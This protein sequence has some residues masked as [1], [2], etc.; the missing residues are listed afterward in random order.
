MIQLPGIYAEIKSE[1]I[2]IRRISVLLLLLVCLLI[3]A[4]EAEAASLSSKAGAVTTSAGALNVRKQ[5]SSG[6]SV[7]YSLKKGSYITL[8]EKHGSWW[9]VEYAAGKYGYCHADYITIVQGSPVTVNTRSGS[10]N[11]R[12]GAGTSY[13]KVGSLYKGQTVLFLKNS[14]GWS[15]VL[16]D[17]VKTGWVSEQYLSNYNAAVSLTVP[18]YKQSDVRWAHLMIGASGKTFDQIGCATTAIAMMESYRQGRNIFPDEMEKQLKYTSSGNVY[19]PEHY[20]TVTIL[21]L[22]A[23]YEK[24]RQG[25]PVLLGATN[26][27]GSQHWVVVVGF[28]GG[29]NLR[30]S[31]FKIHDPGTKSRYNLQQFLDVYPNFY[32]YFYY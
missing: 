26:Q 9:K 24:L 29:D 14:G 1:V 22:N 16:Y 15:R 17:G 10:L 25:R 11:V 6:S 18:N 5:P 13:E 2:V 23:I 7:V 20:K 3:V 8:M 30:A 31:A 28:E 4:P 19:W 12:S 32:K 21:S 27:Y